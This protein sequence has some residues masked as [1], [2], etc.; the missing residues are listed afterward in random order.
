MLLILLI[1]ALVIQTFILFCCAAA[2]NDQM[3]REISDQEQIEF[4]KE[5]CKNHQ[6]HKKM[7]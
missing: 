6:G 5:W 1:L 7:Q 3:S 2:G 4:L